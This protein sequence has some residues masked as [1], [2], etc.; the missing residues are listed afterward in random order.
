MFSYFTSQLAALLGNAPY[1]WEDTR[2]T[3]LWHLTIS[4]LLSVVSHKTVNEA[5]FFH[6]LSI[7]RAI[8]I[9]FRPA[10]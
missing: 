5:M 1:V 7:C 4:P 10:F 9:F 3:W 2:K 6:P 8:V